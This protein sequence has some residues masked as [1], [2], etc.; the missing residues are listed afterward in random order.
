MTNQTALTI[1]DFTNT[2]EVP[3]NAPKPPAW[4]F[5][6]N[7]SIDDA[8]P[9]RFMSMEALE[10]W[11]QDRHAES[12][13]LTI[14]AITCE[15]LYDGAEGEKAAAAGEWKPVL[16]FEET[17]TGLVINKTRGQQMKKLANSPLL[18][19]WA[20]VGQ[21]ALKVGVFNGKAQIGITAV[22]QQK[23]TGRARPD[24]DSR[25]VEDLVDDLFA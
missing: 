16:W 20:K 2:I 4:M 9:Q 1:L 14:T 6:E 3:A 13:I 11:L 17:E 18:K 10:E 22:P 8:L 19:H 23:P 5:D 25:P 15:L 12:R 21:I 7:A 24:L